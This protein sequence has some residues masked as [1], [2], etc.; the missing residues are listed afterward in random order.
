MTKKLKDIL[1]NT[2]LVP[3]KKK[4]ENVVKEALPRPNSDFM[5]GI[6]GVQFD[7]L[8]HGFV[9]VIDYMGN[10]ASVVQAARVS[11]GAGTKKISEDRGLL[12]YLMR[13]HHSTPFEMAE[14]KIHVKLPI[15]V[16]RQWIRHRTAS[17]NEYSARYSI[18]ED[19]F[20]IPEPENLAVQSSDNKQ[21]RGQILNEEQA[22]KVRELLIDDANRCYKNYEKMIDED[23]EI[24]LARELARMDL[25]VNSYTQWYWKVNLHNFLNFLRLR[26]DGHA[27]YEIRVYAELLLEILKGWCPNTCEAFMDYRVNAVSLSAQQWD[28]I[29]NILVNNSS[30]LNKMP[31][32]LTKREWNEML[33]LIKK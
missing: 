21:G 27:Q 8:D 6:I 14:I 22:K 24:Q 32:N 2:K 13:H 19:E 30:E 5:D 28:Y 26:I 33:E 15:F 10:D 31:S 7:V 29:K 20:Y 23:G 18:M 17:V 12:R 25:T 4:G 3:S 16:A 9:R 1:K 11:Y